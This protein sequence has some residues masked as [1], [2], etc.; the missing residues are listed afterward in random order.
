MGFIHG[1]SL[2]ALAGY[3]FGRMVDNMSSSDEETSANGGG[4]GYNQWSQQDNGAWGGQRQAHVWQDE[5]QLRNTFRFS[6]L[7]LASYI[8]RADG[9]VMHSEMELV[10]NWF[11]TNF[12][13]DAQA[14]AEQVLDELFRKQRE[15]GAAEYRSAVISSCHQLANMLTYE[16]RLT[17]LHFLVMIAQADGRVTQDEVKALRDCAS[18]LGIVASDF[19]SELN[20]KQGGNDLDAAYKVLGVSPSATNDELK[21]AYREMA[22]KNHPDRVASLG[23]EVRQAAE[24]KLQEI[25]AAKE[26]IWKARGL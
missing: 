20:L 25:N 18:A 3:V 9:R 17:L 22:L 24:R 21:R 2:G 11:R 15:L 8:I 1:G 26:K 23:D 19:E 10:R 16:Q 14:D 7:V 6:I 4:Q 5:E 13:P 12:G